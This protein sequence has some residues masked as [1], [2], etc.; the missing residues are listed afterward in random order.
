[1][2]AKLSPLEAAAR[3]ATL[4]RE[5]REHNR[6]YY[7]KA[8]P[9]IS[10]QEYDRLYRE[11]AELEAAFPE[12]LTPDSPTQ[13]VGG[14]EA[15]PEPGRLEAFVPVRHLSPM[16]SLDNTYSE[17]EVAA[18]F[19]RLE[20]LLPGRAIPTVIEPKVDGVAISLLYE[21][22][23]LVHA[24][25]RGDGL[26]G[27]DVTRN[28][29]TIR[30]IPHRLKP[31]PGAPERMEVRGEVYL[32]KAKFAALNEERQA[33]GETPFANPRNAAAGS[34]KQLDSAI[35]ARRGLGAIFYGTGLVEGDGA[36]W[37]S[38]HEALDAL[39]ACGLPV[40][41]KLWRA[42]EIS[43]ALGAIRALDVERHALPFET[44]GAVIKL[45]VFAQRA[46][47]GHTAKSPRWAMAFK[48]RPEQ[49]QTRLLRISIQV[50]RTGVLTPVAELEPVFV[51]GST[52]A[53]ATLHNEEEVARK[54]IREGDVVVI[55]K[56]GEVIPAVVG[57]CKER[58][59]GAE[60]VFNMPGACP[61]CGSAVSR[62]PAQVAVRCLNPACPAQVR[63]R[64]EHFASRGAMDIE[65][66]G[67]AMVEQLVER[68]LARDVA[69]L[70]ALDAGRL[71]TIPRTGEKS[72][73]NLLGAIEAS[74]TRPLWRLVFGLGIVHVG[75]ASARALAG[76][77][78]TLDR[79]MAATAEELQQLPDVGPVV[80]PAI[81]QHFGRAENRAM[82]ERLRQ[83]GLNFGERDERRER[84]RESAR[85]AGTW[86][87]TGT[88]SRPREEVAEWI[89]EH[90]GKVV[91]SV[92]K[93]TDFLLAGEEAGSKLE[94]A[95]RLGVRVLDEAEFRAMLE[96][97]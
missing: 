80:A 97:D 68:G 46:S 75:V 25:T 14:S 17:E 35:V 67:E 59:T 69:D 20:K 92:S 31:I 43:E 64:M 47:V 82:I 56:A 57:V 41:G 24:A 85:L 86:V 39:R 7:E 10:D 4:R 51:S 44:D 95:R 16:L 21:A 5:I 53:R 48:Y 49:A 33:A 76:H 55:E 12:L 19:V 71:A 87:I 9:V 1:M 96:E 50:G 58:R 79:L 74:K 81:V 22:G 23:K 90:G 32:P 3:V 40:H 89:R 78:H 93:K 34:L 52:V 28:I 27:D 11:L 29:R 18:F 83:A 38:H 45:D 63:R 91:A 62:D 13:T 60:R 8:A 65:G 73:A 30:D 6:L 77:F 2:S 37:A 42:R 66:L 88:L 15:G 54:D 36:Q 72:I 84:A 26:V 94:K 61:A 70:Y